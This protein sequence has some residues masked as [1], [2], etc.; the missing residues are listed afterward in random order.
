MAAATTAKSLPGSETESWHPARL[1]PTA[2]I[3]GQEEQ[4]KRATSCLLAVMHAVPE[5]GH[6]LLKELG[7]PKS[8]VIETFAEVRFKDAA[9]KSVI[10]DGAVVCQR[11]KKRW[12]CLVEVKTGVAALKDDQVGCYLDLAREHGF[13]GVLTI[14]NQITANSSETPVSVDGRKLRKTSLWHFSWWRILTE[15]IVQSRY[16]GITD[17]DQ[18]WIL[19]ELIAYLDNEASGAAGFDDMGDK[20][21][22]VRKAAHDGTLRQADPQTRAVAERWEQFTQYLCLGLSQDLGRSASSPRPRGQT[23]A[24]R[25]DELTKV[26]ATDGALDAVL[27][28]PDAVGDLQLRADLRARQTLTSV[29][30]DAPREGRAKPRIN[31]LLRQLREAPDDL[32]VEVAYPNARETTSALLS[33]ARE[34]PDRLVYPPDPKRE[35]R[36]FI[37]T[38]A[39]PMGSKRGKAEGSFVRETR[40]QTFDFYRELVQ[41]LKLWQARPPKLR[42]TPEADEV[43]ESPQPDPP[44]FVA[45]DEHEVGEAS[46]P[47][48]TDL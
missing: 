45:S 21:V 28:V 20:W 17:P 3:R 26:L 39:R 32:R 2:G 43:P 40:A 24:G 8:P 7:A 34:D 38:L 14:S 16:R 1:I 11:G 48:E 12:T 33:E 13:D 27:R 42:D 6:A 5:F 31:W 29:A 4:E 44:P 19:G 23:T 30:L 25:L 10:P 9:G 15:A 37:L 22:S 18:A 36:S 46:N 41:N 47:A 35:P